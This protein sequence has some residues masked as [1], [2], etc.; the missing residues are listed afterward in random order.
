MK[1]SQ[2][3]IES[4]ESGYIMPDIVELGDWCH[5]A[6]MSLTKFA[7]ELDAALAADET[8]RRE[9]EQDRKR[10]Q[11]PDWGVP[12]SSDAEVSNLEKGNPESSGSNICV[13]RFAPG[14]L[15]ELLSVENAPHAIQSLLGTRKVRVFATGNP[16]TLGLSA[17]QST[18]ENSARAADAQGECTLL[19]PTAAFLVVAGTF[20]GAQVSPSAPRNQGLE[21][22]PLAAWVP[23]CPRALDMALA[24][25]WERLKLSS[26]SPLQLEFSL[27]RFAPR[28]SHGAVEDI[29]S[30][31]P[32]GTE[33]MAAWND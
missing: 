13:L 24:E 20:G 27:D 31:H 12:K 33:W 25:D 2:Q 8:L 10:E 1:L 9:A 26:L 7:I 19:H 21:W 18:Q 16:A 32:N 4:I 28:L 30:E 17:A 5:A 6:G 29:M 11:E 23:L 15:P 22:A 14:A 3:E